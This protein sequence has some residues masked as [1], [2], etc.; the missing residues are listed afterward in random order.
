MRNCR[1]LKKVSKEAV[2]NLDFRASIYIIGGERSL[3]S[4]GF[5][6]NRIVAKHI[7]RK[8]QGEL[9]SKRMIRGSHKYLVLAKNTM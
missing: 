8:L 9:P 2:K 3:K 4:L 6:P 5:K 7:E 1:G